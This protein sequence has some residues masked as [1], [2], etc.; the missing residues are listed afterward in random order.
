MQKCCI[1]YIVFNKKHTKYILF[2]SKYYVQHK[3]KRHITQFWMMCQF[4]RDL[5]NI[6]CECICASPEGR[7][8]SCKSSYSDCQSSHA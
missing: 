1:F 6:T 8:N 7:R 5:S 2:I 3:T 4:I